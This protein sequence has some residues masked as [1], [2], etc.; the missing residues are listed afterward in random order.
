VMVA[1][2][3]IVAGRPAR[4]DA[5]TASG[6]RLQRFWPRDPRAFRTFLRLPAS[7]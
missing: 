2:G 6:L 5:T 3:E 4:V 1:V 7:R